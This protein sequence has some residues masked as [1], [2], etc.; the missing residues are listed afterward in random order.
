MGHFLPVENEWAKWLDIV[1][2][3]IN[4]FDE[5]ASRELLTAQEI[6]ECIIHID[7]KYKIY[8]RN[9]EVTKDNNII[10]GDYDLTKISKITVR[11]KAEKILLAS[12]AY[13][14]HEE[15]LFELNKAYKERL[16][17]NL[18][19]KDKALSWG[20]LKKCL[21]KKKESPGTFLGEIAVKFNH[22][23]KERVQAALRCQKKFYLKTSYLS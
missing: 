18:L 17:G 16:I 19:V 14:T 12:L 8:E 1:T 21:S 5:N 3:L 22:T 4:S 20:D 11:E 13:F 23:R 2:R 10:K 15:L 6:I 9:E 7:N